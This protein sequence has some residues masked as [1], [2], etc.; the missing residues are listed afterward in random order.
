MGKKSP[1][2]DKNFNIATLIT[3]REIRNQKQRVKN[4]AGSD[5]PKI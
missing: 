2:L 4:I 3:Q 5:L 1:F